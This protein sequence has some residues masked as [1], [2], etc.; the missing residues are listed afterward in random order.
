VRFPKTL[1]A[2][3]NQLLAV[4]EV[5]RAGLSVR[6]TSLEHTLVDVLDRPD[7]GGGWE[8]IRRS[9]EM[10]EFFDL[11]VVI[12]YTLLR[13]SATTAAKVGLFLEQHQEALM[14]ERSHLESLPALR[15]CMPHYLVRAVG[16]H[17]TA[18]L[19]TPTRR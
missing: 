10:V 6:V 5:D 4:K 9:L 13:E 18:L 15:P 1:A 8:E 7:L 2:S 16:I 17:R 19:R 3:A 14:V 12:E 11:D